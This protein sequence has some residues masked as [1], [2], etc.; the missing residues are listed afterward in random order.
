MCS[1][2]ECIAVREIVADWMKHRAIDRHW[3]VDDNLTA[4]R[5][6]TLSVVGV[7]ELLV[8]PYEEKLG[9]ALKHTVEEW[10]ASKL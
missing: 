4:E 7:E 5:R 1:S 3:S 9:S 2:N 6:V 8:L 10:L